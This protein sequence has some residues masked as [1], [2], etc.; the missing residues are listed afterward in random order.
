[1]NIRYENI[2]NNLI[3]YGQTSELIKAEVLIGSQARQFNLADEYSD[4]DIIVFV[5][6]IDYFI[7]SDEWINYLGT[8]YISFV[9]KTV[10]G[11]MERRIVFESALDVD[12]I[13]LNAEDLSRI[14]EVSEIVSRAYKILLDKGNFTN[15][16]Q[17]AAKSLKVFSK[18]SEKEFENLINEFWFHVIW[19]GKKVKR[20]ELWVAINCIDGYMKAILLKMIEYDSY[21][22][23]G[24]DYDT[25]HNGRFIE[26]WAEPWV[27]NE[28]HNIYAIYSEKDI[29]RALN[30]TMVLFRKLSVETANKWNYQYPAVCDKYATEWLEIERMSHFE[31]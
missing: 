29:I 3:K 22:S 4:I 24:E 31:I 17:R 1:M 18:P 15:I 2:M 9:E 26:Q 23:H 30:A 13:F 10:A 25:W 14:D 12:L 21:A 20:G 28:F 19:A 8:H 27:V 16:I 7:N 6:D 5:T 11:G